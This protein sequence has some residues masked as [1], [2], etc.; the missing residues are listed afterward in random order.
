MFRPYNTIFKLPPPGESP[1]QRRHMVQCISCYAEFSIAD[2]ITG[3]L[4]TDSCPVCHM[5]SDEYWENRP[6]RKVPKVNRDGRE[7]LPR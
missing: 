2:V 5:T 4:N 7:S 6:H 3:E 1:P